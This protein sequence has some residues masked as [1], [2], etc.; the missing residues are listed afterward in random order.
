LLK[1]K[2]VINDAIVASNI[3]EIIGPKISKQYCPL[4]FTPCLIR[5]TL[6]FDR[7]IDTVTYL[8]NINLEGSIL[9]DAMLPS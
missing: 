4:T 6:I 9:Q 8:V 3:V 1:D 2:I 5:T 7:A